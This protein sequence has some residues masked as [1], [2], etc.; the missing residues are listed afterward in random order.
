MNSAVSRTPKRRKSARVGG[1]VLSA[2]MIA[3][4][5]FVGA[6]Y[7][8]QLIMTG[9]PLWFRTD[10][11]A[12]P[13]HVVIQDRGVRT[14]IPPTD[15]RFAPLVDAFNRSIERGYWSASMGFSDP[16]WA[17]VESNGVIVETQYSEPVRLHGNFVPTTR[18]R[19]LLSGEKIHTTELLFR[20]NPDE[21]DR[22]PLRLKDVSLLAQ[23]VQRAG[24]G[25]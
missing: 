22:I 25:E 6:Y 10:F 18:M 21:W 13:R 2:F 17:L 24:L 19:V 23:A 20:S 14:D 16:T 12:Q 11:D 5:M 3:L 4:L 15:A 8:L 9:D 7:A 1:S